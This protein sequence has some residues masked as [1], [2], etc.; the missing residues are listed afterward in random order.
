MELYFSD[1]YGVTANALDKYG[2]FDISMAS[3]LPLFIDPFLLFSSD[4]AE[5]QELHQEILKYLRFLRDHATDS[6]DQALID[7]WF[8]FKEVKQN[9]LGYTLF[10][11]AGSGLGADFARALHSALGSIVTNFGDETVT[12]SSHLEKL[13][14]IKPGVGKDNI[15]DFTTVLIKAYLLRYTEA[16]AKRH[17][18]ASQRATFMVPRAVFDYDTEAWTAKR[19]VLPK[20]GNDFV[21]LTPAD[22]LTRDDTW[23][24][25][26]D[27]RSKFDQLPAAVPNAELRAQIN[28]YFRRRLGDKPDAKQRA[29]AITETITR[30]PL[31]IDYYIREQERHGDDA[32]S[33]SAA[34]VDDAHAALVAQVKEAISALEQYGGFYDKPNGSYAEALARAKWFKGYIENQD[35]YKLI[36]R[37]GQPFSRESE[38]QLFFGLIWYRTDFDVNREVNNGRGPVDYKISFGSTD[39]SL[40]EFKLGSNKSL[41]RNLENQVPIY[42]AANRT[43]SAVKVIVSYTTKDVERVD[44]ILKKLKL[45]KEKSIVLID[46]RSDNKPSASKAS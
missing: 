46:A 24:S 35:G 6:L 18:K 45:D 32:R 22:L 11:N 13:C 16:F 12:Q 29:K 36:N 37:G 41:E 3:D 8:R 28:R 21:I 10:G 5:Y 31:L 43:G 40:V 15:S 30:Y 2:A 20:R 44:R 39:K 17:I 34:R 9:W 42:Q 14:L 19:Y 1:Y 7:A 23:I 26:R 27:M 38:V 4:K 33:R 25:Q